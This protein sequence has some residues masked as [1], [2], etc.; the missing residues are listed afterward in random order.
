MLKYVCAA[1]AGLIILL[2]VPVF[3]QTEEAPKTGPVQYDEVRAIVQEL[4]SEFTNELADLRNDVDYLQDDVWDLADRLAVLEQGEEAA[5]GA[6]GWRDYHLNPAAISPS[7]CC[8]QFVPM[9]GAIDNHRDMRAQL[10][11]IASRL[12]LVAGSTDDLY[13]NIYG[14]MGDAALDCER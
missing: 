4:I 7:Y 14:N 10:N 5:V 12:A 13:D 1:V 8:G 3:A 11:N 9:Q 2:A 6:T